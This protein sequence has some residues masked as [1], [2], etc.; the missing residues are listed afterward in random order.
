MSNMNLNPDEAMKNV[1]NG[2]GKFNKE[3]VA[4]MINKLS[5]DQKKQLDSILNDKEATKRL[6]ASPQAQAIMKSLS[7]GKGNKK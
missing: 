6:L 1:G 4:A 5:P 3:K 2:D 7:N